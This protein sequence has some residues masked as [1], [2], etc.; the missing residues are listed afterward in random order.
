[1]KAVC[2]KLNTA[3]DEH[4]MLILIGFYLA[5]DNHMI[6]YRVYRDSLTPIKK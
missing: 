2:W 3:S 5:L 6:G 1:M 4:K